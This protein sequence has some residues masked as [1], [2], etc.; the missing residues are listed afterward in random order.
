MTAFWRNWIGKTGAYPI[1]FH[2]LS[3]VSG[4]L[5]ISDQYRQK[6]AGMV[7]S[8]AFFGSRRA[9]G[10]GVPAFSQ[11]GSGWFFTGF[12]IGYRNGFLDM[13]GCLLYRAAGMVVP[14]PAQARRQYRLKRLGKQKSQIRLY[15][16]FVTVH[17][18]SAAFDSFYEEISSIDRSQRFDGS[19]FSKRSTGTDSKRRMDAADRRLFHGKNEK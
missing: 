10:R 1:I 14:N 3:A 4:L 2:E 9:G 12:S 17:Y 18:P 7:G 8:G 5:F 11:D 16:D 19:S 6:P 13:C 15:Q